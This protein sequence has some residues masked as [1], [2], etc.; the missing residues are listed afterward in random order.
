MADRIS[1]GVEDYAVVIIGGGLLVG[2]LAARGISFLLPWTWAIFV[3]SGFATS[4]VAFAFWTGAKGTGAMVVGLLFYGIT[5]GVWASSLSGVVRL[6]SPPEELGTRLALLAAVG[7][8][9]GL[10]GPPVCAG[11]LKLA[12]V[13]SSNT[14]C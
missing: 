4:M 3:C 12:L 6:I 14:Q 8:L 11:E 10:A 2:A 13:G 1:K 9:A 7:G 5:T